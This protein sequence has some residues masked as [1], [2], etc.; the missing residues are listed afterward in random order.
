MSTEIFE[1]FV[2][3]NEPFVLYGCSF[4]A[5][6]SGVPLISSTTFFAGGPSVKDG[7][8]MF[9][10]YGFYYLNSTNHLF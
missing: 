5:K 1:L 6:A 8:V 9:T 3:T 10:D 4:S 2:G 7:P